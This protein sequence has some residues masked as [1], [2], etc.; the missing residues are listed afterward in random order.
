VGRGKRLGGGEA[1]V[2]ERGRSLGDARDLIEREIVR[3]IELV[4]IEAGAAE[5]IAARGYEQKQR[6]ELWTADAVPQNR[7]V[8]AHVP[9]IASPSAAIRRASTIRATPLRLADRHRGRWAPRR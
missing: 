4:E 9:I 3:A 5:R 2:K 6:L 8:L 1:E 7:E